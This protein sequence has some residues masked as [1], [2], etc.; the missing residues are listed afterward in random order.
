MSVQEKYRLIA[1]SVFVRELCSLVAASRRIVDPEFLELALH[2]HSEVL[3][4][5]LQA[6]LDRCEGK[7][8]S[9]VLLGYGLCGNALSGLRARSIPLILPRAHDCCTILLGSSAA[10]QGEFGE[11]LSAPWS[12]CGYVER[13]SDY[14]RLSETGK[15]S[16]YGMEYGELVAQYGED[17]AAY[18]WETLHP[19]LDEP[20]L[21]YIDTPST[22]AL[23][24]SAKIAADA[25][26]AGKE[27]RLI[28][29]DER[30]LRALV[31]G[32]WDDADFLTVPPGAE[33]A[34]LYDFEQVMEAK[35]AP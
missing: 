32:P 35:P 7:G 12:S 29:G 24:R 30:L 18:L 21:R 20:V 11:T 15:S 28:R 25:A 2:E 27:F 23:G 4:Q 26:A 33:I 3:R 17:N 19:E 31:E 5:G 16:G 6:A 10:F 34:P 13:G 8:Y 22:S 1:C 9:A 14:M